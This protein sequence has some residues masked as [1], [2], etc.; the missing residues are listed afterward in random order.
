LILSDVSATL[1][2]LPNPGSGELLVGALLFGAFAVGG[3][4][5]TVAVAPPAAIFGNV[6]IAWIASFV[7][8]NTWSTL[9]SANEKDG[10]EVDRSNITSFALELVVIGVAVTGNP[11]VEF[12]R[13]IPYQAYVLP[14]FPVKVKLETENRQPSRMVTSPETAI[15]G[16]VMG[17]PKDV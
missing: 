7:T 9:K 6:T 12:V 11:L 15:A 3:V 13:L 2:V 5:T 14:G 8:S 1:V 17:A 4:V 16:R 10:A